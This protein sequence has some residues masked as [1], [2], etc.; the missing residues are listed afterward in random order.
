MTFKRYAMIAESD[1]KT[2]YRYLPENYEIEGTVERTDSRGND[3]IITVIGGRDKADWT[4]DYVINRLFS[5][6][7]VADEIGISHSI[8][9]CIEAEEEQCSAR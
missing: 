1:P 5:G 6:L 3:Y 7:I 4:L 8:M 9:K 2:V